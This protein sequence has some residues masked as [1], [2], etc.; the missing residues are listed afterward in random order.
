MIARLGLPHRY[1][2]FGRARHALACD[3]LGGVWIAPAQ[4]VEAARRVP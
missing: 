1:A 3:A 2:H 4:N